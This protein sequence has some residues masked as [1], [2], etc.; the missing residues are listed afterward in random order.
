MSGIVFLA[1]MAILLILGNETIS[2][3][4][5]VMIGLCFVVYLLYNQKI[6]VDRC[7]ILG[8]TYY[9]KSIKATALLREFYILPGNQQLLVVSLPDTE[10]FVSIK[11]ELHH[12]CAARLEVA[13][14]KAKQQSDPLPINVLIY[15]DSFGD[16]QYR[17]PDNWDSDLPYITD[18]GVITIMKKK[19]TPDEIAL[20]MH[21]MS[22][23]LIG[24]SLILLFSNEK[25][26]LV[27]L[28]IG[29]SGMILFVPSTKIRLT[30]IT[31]CGIIAAEKAKN[32]NNQDVSPTP[33][34]SSPIQETPD[35]KPEET[36]NVAFDD[37][38][39]KKTAAVSAIQIITQKYEQAKEAQ[40]SQSHALETD[41]FKEAE[42]IVDTGSA[43]DTTSG[44][45]DQQND[46]QE[47]LSERDELTETLNEDSSHTSRSHKNG[48]KKKKGVSSKQPRTRKK[49]KNSKESS[50]GEQISFLSVMHES[51]LSDAEDPQTSEDQPLIGS[52]KDS[53]GCTNIS[54]ADSDKGDPLLG[55]TGSDSNTVDEETDDSAELE[56]MFHNTGGTFTDGPMDEDID[57]GD[58]N[59]TAD[60]SDGDAEVYG[61]LAS[62]GV[63]DEEDDSDDIDIA[64]PN[65]PTHIFDSYEVTEDQD[66]APDGVEVIPQDDIQIVP[67]KKYRRNLYGDTLMKRRDNDT[68]QKIDFVIES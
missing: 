42:Q 56:E 46:S 48:R 33:E 62:L 2:G 39:V 43:I 54:A 19:K 60:D 7:T 17:I 59:E 32:L 65:E 23:I 11:A 44:V 8:K 50:E 25:A 34:A 28:I 24:I 5:I 18:V 57:S 52:A 27:L 6:Y 51:V 26:A 37:A 49:G 29:I 1:L 41:N 14:L 30:K 45:G 67:R 63:I 66:T 15:D 38:K 9:R 20:I 22:E 31:K 64:S 10:E 47:E 4:V 3:A 36:T 58:S 13:Y 68:P 53:E 21:V 16:K 40:T 55:T 12:D 61:D 35:A